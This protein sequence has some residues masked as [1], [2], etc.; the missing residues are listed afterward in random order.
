[1]NFLNSDF[2]GS[3]KGVDQFREFYLSLPSS[4]VPDPEKVPS[5]SRQPIEDDSKLYGKA[6]PLATLFWNTAVLSERTALNYVRNL[7]AYGVRVGMYG[8][9]GLML[10]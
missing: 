4:S 10:A 8:G 7:L 6:G 9:M 3:S 1:M 2:A 5:S